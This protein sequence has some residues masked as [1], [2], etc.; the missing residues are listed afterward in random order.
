[1]NTL[2]KLMYRFA[3]SRRCRQCGGLAQVR[4]RERRPVPGG[5]LL[6]ALRSWCSLEEVGS[7]L[8]QPETVDVDVDLFVV[9]GD[10]A[11]DGQQLAGRVVVGPREI[12]VAVPHLVA[13]AD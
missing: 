9:E 11:G 7:G 1:M 8:R 4:D 2:E 6:A 10:Q 3:F 5:P 13:G 12:L